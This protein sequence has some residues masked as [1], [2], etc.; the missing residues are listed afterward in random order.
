M[1]KT[2]KTIERF[3][4][5][6][7]PYVVLGYRMGVIAN[8]L[9]GEDPFKKTVTILTGT[10]PPISCIID[11]VQLSSRCTLGKGNLNV[12]DEKQPAARFKDKN[13][14]TLDISVKSEI[15]EEIEKAFKE[16]KDVSGKIFERSDE[17]L[18]EM[19]FKENGS[20]N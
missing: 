10:K 15:L 18:F 11:G 12:L 16:K 17:E 3:H 19:R 9:L 7:G 14:S 5:H 8:K 13:G 2:L 20:N 1:N 4:G 6:L